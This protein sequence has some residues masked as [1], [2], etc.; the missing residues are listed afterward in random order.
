MCFYFG[1]FTDVADPSASIEIKNAN[2]ISFTKS[3]DEQ[4]DNAE[5]QDK[6]TVRNGLD[7]NENDKVN[8]TQDDTN[9]TALEGSDLKNG[10]ITDESYVF[11]NIFYFP[12][13]KKI[14]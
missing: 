10:S 12:N 14:S 2:T 13:L 7:D 6:E 5:L 9:T 8:K 3:I 1:I 4:I 11:Q